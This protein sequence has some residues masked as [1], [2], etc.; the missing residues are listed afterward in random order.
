MTVHWD[1]PTLQYVFDSN[2]T[3][4][5]SLD[6]IEIPNEGTVRYNQIAI[7]LVQANIVD[8]VDFLGHTRSLNRSPDSPPHSFARSRFFRFGQQTHCNF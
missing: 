6:I 2:T 4:P 8:I 1:N 3:Y 7:L 5:A